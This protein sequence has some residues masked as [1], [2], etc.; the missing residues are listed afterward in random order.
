VSNDQVH[1]P[2]VISNSRIFDV[3]IDEANLELVHHNLMSLYGVTPVVLIVTKASSPL[4]RRAWMYDDMRPKHIV[5]WDY[6]DLAAKCSL[7]G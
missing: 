1:I 4:N 2:V 6:I 5:V 3:L 7:G